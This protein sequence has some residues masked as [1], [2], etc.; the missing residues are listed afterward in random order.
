[1]AAKADNR[2]ENGE[3]ELSVRFLRATIV[4][5]CAQ[6]GGSFSLFS[7]AD[8]SAKTVISQQTSP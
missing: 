3:Q 1:M 5:W 6:G 8:L 7:R 2:V 4:E